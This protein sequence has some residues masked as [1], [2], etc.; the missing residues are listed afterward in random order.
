M[1]A[2]IKYSRIGAARF[3][4]HLDMQRA[5]AR[6]LRRT[7]LPVK[8]SE[9]FNPHILTSF[10]SPLSVGIATMGDYLEVRMEQAV[11]G[12]VIKERLNAILPADL[13]IIYAGELPE[14]GP[15]LMAISHS[16]RY[17]MIFPHDIEKTDS[18][19][20]AKTF[21]AVDRKGR[22]LD[23]RPLVYELTAEG[24]MAAARIANSSAATLNPIVLAA[25]LAPGQA[26]ITRLE[27]YCMDGAVKPFFELGN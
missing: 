22:N 6:A 24:N 15:K 23:I 9:G 3:I 11:A 13:T 7:E 1:R 10:A 25:A 16:A 26:R 21:M 19:M 5:F 12:E 4:S 20:E 14:N 2:I 17:E 8:Y 18:F 27:C